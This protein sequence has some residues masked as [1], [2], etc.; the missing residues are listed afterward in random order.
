MKKALW[1]LLFAAA[2]AAPCS[3]DVLLVGPS[4]VTIGQTFDVTVELK[5]IFVNHPIDTLIAF[6]FNFNYDSSAL[7]LE[8]IAVDSSNWLD[9]GLTP[10]QAGGLNFTG[11]TAGTPEPL[12]LATVTLQANKLGATNFSVTSDPNDLNTGLIFDSG[13][14]QF[15]SRDAVTVA[16]PEPAAVW[17]LGSLA[18][19]FFVVRRRARREPVA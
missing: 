5:N 17:L 4:T 11:F 18:A 7:T 10:P 16:A 8:N 6:G 12:V 3:A 19:G 9:V 13:Y 1:T 2:V 15:A 14:E